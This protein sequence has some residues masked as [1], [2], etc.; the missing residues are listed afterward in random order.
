MVALLKQ[1]SK[2]MVAQKP[3]KTYEVKNMFKRQKLED[4][5]LANSQSQPQGKATQQ[6]KAVEYTDDEGL[7]RVGQT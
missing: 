7:L 5:N 1:K 6:S 2:I 3:R 4:S